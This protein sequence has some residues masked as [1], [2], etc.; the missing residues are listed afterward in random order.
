M[1]PMRVDPVE[2]FERTIETT[3][4]MIEIVN[5]MDSEMFFSMMKE[6]KT[7]K[8]LKRLEDHVLK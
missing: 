4:K 1:S 6:G 2:A 3:D 8:I 5:Q 7:L